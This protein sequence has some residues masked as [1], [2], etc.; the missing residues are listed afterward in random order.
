MTPATTTIK[1]LE[2]T[3]KRICA[4]YAANPS[5][6]FE[7][8]NLLLVDLFEKSLC[9]GSASD[10]TRLFAHIN[11]TSEEI[12]SSI[13]SLKDT[14]LSIQTDARENMTTRMLETKKEY[15]EE[16]RQIVENPMVHNICSLLE[17]NN[18]KLI[19]KTTSIINGVMPNVAQIRDSLCD[20][21]KTISEDTRN[22][23]KSME[24]YTE[25]DKYA[26]KECINHFEMKT[27]IML[28][29][30]QQPIY[31]FISAS[32]DRVTQATHANQTKTVKEIGE[33]IECFRGET[34]IGGRVVGAASNKMSSVLTRLFHSAEISK[35]GIAPEN[36]GTILL[37]RL[38]KPNIL[39]ENKDS[40]ENISAEDVNA[41]LAL[42]DEYSCNGIFISQQSGISTKKNYQIEINANN[43]VVV[44]LH[45]VEYS[46]SAVESAVDIIDSLTQ[47]L[48]NIKGGSAEDD[49]LIPKEI[50]DGINTEYQLFMTQRNAV[51][52]VF[53]ESQKKVLAQIDELRFPC[54]DK[55]LSTRY[56]TPIQRPGL[57]CDLCKSFTANNL[58]ALAAHKRG[59]NRKNLVSVSVAAA[60]AAA[61]NTDAIQ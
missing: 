21:H 34:A 52:E 1:K 26:I 6:H 12:K 39:V 46:G 35:Q 37:K 59:C 49:V 28:Q 51:V 53:K 43:N 19:D 58:K 2:V 13:A 32:E 9:N 16:M 38:R 25:S 45:M 61:V 33:F 22:L 7:T 42:I 30:L 11:A 40:P 36:N 31:S 5:I 10:A 17:T 20:F 29:N 24:N 14:M 56:S 4:F 48:R 15:I 23:Q 41:F 50:L 18:A 3:N 47:K 8:V 57:K 54:L 60:A 55:Y 44:F 27:S